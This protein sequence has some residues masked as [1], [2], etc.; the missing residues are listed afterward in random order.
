MG[1]TNKKILKTLNN[2]FKKNLKK[3][4]KMIHDVSNSTQNALFEL[5]EILELKTL[6][7]HDY[8]LIRF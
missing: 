2:I 7:E 8:A 6:K 3:K 4:G 1:L 5:K